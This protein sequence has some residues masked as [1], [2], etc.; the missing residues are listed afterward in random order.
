M[1]GNAMKWFGVAMTVLLLSG[2]APALAAEPA[3]IEAWVKQLASP[4]KPPEI[5]NGEVKS[6]PEGFDKEAQKQVFS[7][8]KKL[9]ELGPPV[10]P[11]LFDHLKDKPYSFTEFEPLEGD[12]ENYSVGTACRLII[13]SQLQPYGEDKTFGEGE[14]QSRSH[15]PSYFDQLKLSDPKSARFWWQMRNDK[16]L[17]ELQ[18]ETLEWVIE[19][20]AK[21]G[22]EYSLE[23]RQ[24]LNDVLK[25]LRDS[26]KALKPSWPFGK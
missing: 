9:Y 10:F 1:L 18:I 4:N 7:A 14:Q 22:R 12:A 2:I 15:R 6:Y 24:H 8:W 11:Y 21:A 23:E 20:E 13:T 25:D 5:D 17:Y 19:R 26:G 16:S 3:E